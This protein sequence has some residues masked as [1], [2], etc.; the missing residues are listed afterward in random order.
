MQ[1]HHSRSALAISPDGKW[2]A[3]GRYDGTLSLYDTKSYKPMLG[4]LLA[5]DG[6]GLELACGATMA[7]QR[8][9]KD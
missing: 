4:L 2:L 6:A 5:F 1:H 7:E 8:S 9:G 3:A